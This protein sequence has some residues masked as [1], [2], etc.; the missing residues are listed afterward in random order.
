MI[1]FPDNVWPVDGGSR[2]YVGIIAH[3]VTEI[4][5]LSGIDH[6][7]DYRLHLGSFNMAM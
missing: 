1:T 6:R 4:E 3:V 2:E 5:T 7:P